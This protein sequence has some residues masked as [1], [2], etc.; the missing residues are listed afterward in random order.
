MSG[1]GR[2]RVRSVYPFTEADRALLAAV[3]PRL[4]IIHGGED[5]QAWVDAL[6]D[7]EA[8]ILVASTVPMS[9]AENP[10]LRTV[11]T[12]AAGVEGI[13][14][15]D[16]WSRGIV[17]T[18]GSGIHAV[19][20][21]EYLVAGVLHAAQ[22][23]PARMAAHAERRWEGAESGLAGLRLRGR[24]AVIVGY[25]S[26]GRETARLLDALGVRITAVKRDPDRRADP[27]WREPGTGDPEGMI[28]DRWVA[29][30]D[31]ADA[32]ADA[33]HLLLTAPLTPATRGIVSAAVLAR[34]RP[35]AWLHNVG[36]GALVDQAA[37]GAALHAGRLGGA[38]VDVTTP[39]PL[40]PD[41]PLWAAPNLLVTPHI[42]AIGDRDHLWHLTAV[43]LAEQLRRDLAGEPQ[44]NVVEAG[45]G[46]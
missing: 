34:M 16:P 6:I 45:A 2:I 33:D 24:R 20:M 40:P 9:S 10:R 28:P 1:A 38:I 4:E 39:E 8:E 31:L 22:R 14:P 3:H 19:H 11:F 46:Y 7:P 32:V 5:S 30:G 21:A 18:N 36:R 23:I 42:S 44:I 27:G 13:P 41:D 29:P 35:D 17:V 25:G 43:I 15:L 12:A 26:I 37:L